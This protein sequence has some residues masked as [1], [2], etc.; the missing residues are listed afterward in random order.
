M[1]LLLGVY[2]TGKRLYD[3]HKAKTTQCVLCGFD[4]DDRVH[5]M[6][7]CPSLSTIRNSFLNQL[8]TTSTSLRDHYSTSLEF[9]LYILD[10][11]SPRVPEIIK[12]GWKSKEEIYRI[13]RNFCF[14]MH[15]K[16]T[17]LVESLNT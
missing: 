3:M 10:P 5:F 7:V 9:L 6:L 4:L 12:K 15:K 13:S 14:S 2:N 1:W 16:R 17:K 8:M 11:Y